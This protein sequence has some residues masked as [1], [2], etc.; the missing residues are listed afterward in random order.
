MYVIDTR[1]YLD[2]K[3]DIGP[4]NG[5]ARKMADFITSV[6]SHASDF[7]RPESTPGPVC[8]KCRKCDNR[9]VDTDM[10]DD[11]TVFW[12]C[13]ARGTEG[14]RDAQSQRHPTGRTAKARDK[15]MSGMIVTPRHGSHPDCRAAGGKPSGRPLQYR[16]SAVLTDLRQ[17][18]CPLGSRK[19]S[20]PARV[21]IQRC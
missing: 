13:T 19:H 9:R 18:T 10:T 12:H 8:F 17:T 5:P 21:D 16:L 7:D 15:Q 2:D 6:V 14:R 1:H 4:P 3:G 20:P 11:D